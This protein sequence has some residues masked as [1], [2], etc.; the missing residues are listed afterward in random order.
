MDVADKIGSGFV[1][2]AA[3]NVLE[4]IDLARKLV[5]YV[6]GVHRCDIRRHDKVSKPHC[7]MF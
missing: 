7:A 4:W 3:C 2:A 5:T 6:A 1:H